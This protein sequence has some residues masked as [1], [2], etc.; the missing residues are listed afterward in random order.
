MKRRLLLIAVCLLLGAVV[1]VA[2]AYSCVFWAPDWPGGSSVA[3]PAGSDWVREPGASWP[4]PNK[5]FA[6]SAFGNSFVSRSATPN[7]PGGISYYQWTYHFGWPFRTVESGGRQAGR[8]IEELIGVGRK[9]TVTPLFGQ[10]DYYRHLPFHPIWPGFAINTIFYAA[11][12]WSLIPGPFALR[13]LLRV[14]CGLCPKCAYP[15]S[16]S[17][18]CTECGCGLAK[19]LRTP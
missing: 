14:R 18:V 12:L 3:L 9:I 11:L 7:K 17:S 16:Q 8:R 19:R 2:V 15:M 13:R 6:S 1:N 5:G 4:A 10:T